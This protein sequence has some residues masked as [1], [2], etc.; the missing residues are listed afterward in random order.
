MSAACSVNSRA[1]IGR[2]PLA[3]C[4]DSVI[5]EPMR[6][7]TIIDGSLITIIDGLSSKWLAA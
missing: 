7:I 6:V 3:N 2:N 1:S 5:D 4:D